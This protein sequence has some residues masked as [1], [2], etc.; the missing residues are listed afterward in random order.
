MKKAS[1][2]ADSKSYTEMAFREKE[3]WHQRR[4]KMSLTKKIETLDR[5]LE[6]RKHIPK[7]SSGDDKPESFPS[8]D[9]PGPSGPP[10]DSGRVEA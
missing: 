3:K 6:M 8:F 5:L 1:L 4:A 10:T 9:S 7:I 2:P